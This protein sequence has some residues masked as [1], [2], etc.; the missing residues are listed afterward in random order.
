MLCVLYREVLIPAKA[1]K[2]LIQC[3]VVSVK[4]GL[5]GFIKLIS[6]CLLSARKADV[7]F[8]YFSKCVTI[9]NF[10]SVA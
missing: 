3:E 6:N 7:R 8:G 10:L 1:I 9:H 4:I 5:W 2:F